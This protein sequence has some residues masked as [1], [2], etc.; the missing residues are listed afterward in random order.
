MAEHEER[1][2]PFVFKTEMD[3]DLLADAWE[4]YGYHVSRHGT[5]WAKVW[6][7]PV[8]HSELQNE[9][10]HYE[11]HKGYDYVDP[12]AVW[13]PT[14]FATPEES[15]AFYKKCV[16]LDYP[17]TQNGLLWV[18]V[19]CTYYQYHQLLDMFNI[20]IRDITEYIPRIDYD[21]C[22]FEEAIGKNISNIGNVLILEND[23]QTRRLPFETRYAYGAI[24]E[25]LRLEPQGEIAVLAETV[26]FLKRR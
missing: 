21:C 2:Y 1:R 6:C 19:K 26:R 22:T 18:R 3:R 8:Q 9:I 10:K 11:D 20:P 12:N 17:A 5:L 16:E 23:G 7:T 13:H 25:V 4:D 14:D 15:D 24:A